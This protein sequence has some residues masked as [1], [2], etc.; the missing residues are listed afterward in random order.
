MNDVEHPFMTID[1][2]ADRL[3]SQLS[4]N[5]VSDIV[6][7]AIAEGRDEITN[8]IRMA[9]KNIE[10]RLYGTERFRRKPAWE[11]SGMLDRP[12]KISDFL[13]ASG[14]VPL[15]VEQ[16]HGKELARLVL[17]KIFAECKGNTD[18]LREL[19]YSSSKFLQ[20]TDWSVAFSNA[21]PVV[22]DDIFS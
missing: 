6:A 21:R 11:S 18:K 9:R 7:A 5:K 12:P 10:D 13:P 17:P 3:N 8:R 15:T 19:I 22:H 2:L 4:R 20:D 1:H 14:M 16:C